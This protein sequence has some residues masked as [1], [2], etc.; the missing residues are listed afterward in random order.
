MLEFYAT[1]NYRWE[2]NAQRRML[3][4][5][6]FFS[7]RMRMLRHIGFAICDALLGWMMWLTAT[8]RWLVKAPSTTEQLQQ[9][10]QQSAAAHAQ[11]NLLGN[12]KN[13]IVRDNELRARQDLYWRREQEEMAGI[14]QDEAV[15][16]ATTSVLAREDYDKTRRRA[17]MY[18]E[19]VLNA[20][21]VG[22]HAQPGR[23][24]A[25]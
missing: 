19:Q 24:S 12:V 5:V 25:A 1:W 6:E 15:R 18:V 4:E 16:T 8:N 7:Q 3:A 22:S 20:T 11:I 21:A 14:M 2:A 9:L 13:A 10:A 23:A 17:Q